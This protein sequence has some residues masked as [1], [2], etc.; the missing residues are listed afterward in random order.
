MLINGFV[1]L[2]KGSLHIFSL[3]DAVSELEL[4]VIVYFWALWLIF[5]G[6]AFWCFPTFWAFLDANRVIQKEWVLT[7]LKEFS[8]VF[9]F[10]LREVGHV[11]WDSLHFRATFISH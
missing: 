3:W 4:G 2:I 11:L 7:G 8:E 1:N 6:H 5:V 10:V 9:I